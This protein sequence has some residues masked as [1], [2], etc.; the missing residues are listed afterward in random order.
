VG[1]GELVDPLGEP[2]IEN[3]LGLLISQDQAAGLYTYAFPA[4]AFGRAVTIQ[5]GP[6]IKAGAARSGSVEIDLRSVLARLRPDDPESRAPV[7]AADHGKGVGA[8]PVARSARNP[9]CQNSLHPGKSCLALELAGARETVGTTFEGTIDGKPVPVAM[10]SVGYTTE[11]SGVITGGWTEIVIFYSSLD[12]L[13]GSL[14][15]RETGSLHEVI[16]G[17]W[18]IRLEP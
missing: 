18:K 2:R 1:G 16:R 12:D 7:L 4:Y 8:A 17:S 10:T 3:Q 11:P 13:R 15:L 6:W 5:F 9:F 14:M